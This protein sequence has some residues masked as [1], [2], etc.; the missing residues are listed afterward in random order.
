MSEPVVA[1]GL[2]RAFAVFRKEFREAF[3]DRRVLFNTVL[4]PLL[5]T[6]L[7]LAMVGGMVKQQVAAE[8]KEKLTVAIVNSDKAPTVMASLKETPN[9]EFTPMT[10]AEA[11]KAI[12]DRKLRAAAVLPENADTLLQASNTVPVTILLDQGSQASQTAAGKLRDLFKDRGAAI[13]GERLISNGMPLDFARPFTVKE[14]SIKG[15]GSVAMMVLAGFLPYMLALYAIVGGLSPANDA[16]AGE[17]ER[18][19]LETLLVSPASRF[20][21]ALGKFLNIATIA[22]ISCILSVVGLLWPF[23]TGW[24]GFNWITKGSGGLHLEPFTIM[25]MILAM[26]PLAVLGA[27]L[28][29]G[30]STFARNQKEAQTYLMPVMLI[31]S[32]TA[33]LSL[34]C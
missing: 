13:T 5:I 9:T 32:I 10:Q 17:K 26:L 16:V 19:T 30:I 2:S 8:Q 11:E 21:L 25:V 4:S 7:I 27:G 31:V 24:S 20:E 6:P 23:Y 12:R 14:Q 18:G 34:L 29:L 33:V 28:L 1:P 3:R 22:F 15:G